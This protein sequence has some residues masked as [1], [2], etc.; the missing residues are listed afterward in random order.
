[1][2]AG[3][4]QTFSLRLVSL[5]EWDGKPQADPEVFDKKENRNRRVLRTT[6]RG[7]DEN[8]ENVARQSAAGLL[9]SKQFYQ[10]IVKD[11]LMG[12]NMSRCR[13]R[14]A[15]QAGIT[16]GCMCIAEM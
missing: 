2:A 6:D 12:I 1:M 5:A 4:S 16:I 3:E 14:A 13:R 8:G 15:G 9:W 11:W 7:L 10:Y